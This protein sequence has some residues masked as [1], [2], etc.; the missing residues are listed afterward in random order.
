MAGDL[1]LH[2]PLVDELVLRAIGA[3]GPDAVHLL[4]GALMA[5][6]EKGGICRGKL[7]VIEPVVA[8]LDELGDGP[9]LQ[10]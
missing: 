7:E 9:R 4:P 1:I 2:D 5:I 3:D 8:V 10:V 6:H